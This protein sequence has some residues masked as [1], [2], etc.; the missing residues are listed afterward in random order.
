MGFDI[1]QASGAE[2]TVSSYLLYINPIVVYDY[3][4]YVLEKSHQCS[5]D[6]G[7]GCVLIEIDWNMFGLHDETCV[8]D[9]Y[10]ENIDY[11]SDCSRV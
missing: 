1:W 2:V 7:N 5:T 11:A 8:S 9:Y 10:V 3:D 4:I 6:V